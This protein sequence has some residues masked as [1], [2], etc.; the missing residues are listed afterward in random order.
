MEDTKNEECKIWSKSTS[1]I[2]RD[3][4]VNKH[5]HQ[6]LKIIRSTYKNDSYLV[7]IIHL[8]KHTSNYN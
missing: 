5:G 7:Q 4:Q 1:Q 8:G 3:I 6:N 2:D